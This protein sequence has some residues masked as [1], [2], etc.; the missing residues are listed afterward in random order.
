M[1]AGTFVQ[2]PGAYSVGLAWGVTRQSKQGAV[3]CVGCGQA[4]G[5]LGFR[6]VEGAVLKEASSGLAFQRTLDCVTEICGLYD[7]RSLDSVPS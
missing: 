2:D 3:A 4:H 7:S 6:H 5:K 1:K